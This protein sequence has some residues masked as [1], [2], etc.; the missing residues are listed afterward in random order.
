MAHR[1][2]QVIARWL[3]EHC[4]AL[5]EPRGI[6]PPSAP[7]FRALQARLRQRRV[8]LAVV[9]AVAEVRGPLWW[10]LHARVCV[11]VWKRFLWFRRGGGVGGVG[12]FE[13]TPLPPGMT[14]LPP[15]CPYKQ[16]SDG[17]NPLRARSLQVLFATTVEAETV[18]SLDLSGTLGHAALFPLLSKSAL[19]GGGG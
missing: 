9:W 18:A 8:H 16:A 4:R 5:F 2:W 13:R 10:C 14:S 17:R 15:R 3:G 19:R 11:R 12:S 1:G 6:A 7:T